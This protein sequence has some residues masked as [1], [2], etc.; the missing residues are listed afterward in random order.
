MAALTFARPPSSLC[1]LRLSAIGDVTHMLP[2]VATLQQ[3]WPETEI[4]WIIGRVEYQLVKSLPGIKF[5]IFDK[6][7]GIFEYMTLRRKLSG[8]RF[9]LLLMMQV[10]L[11]AN[12]ISLLIKSDM[13]IGYDRKRARD[14]HRLF[15]NQYIEGPDRVHVLDTFF[16]FL[17]KLGIRERRMNW[18]LK[19]D[20]SSRGFAQEIIGQQ[21]AVAI[22]PCSSARANNWRNWPEKNYSRVIDYLSTKGIRVIIT[23]GPAEEELLFA[24]RVI[25]NCDQKPVNLVGKTSLMQLLALLE[26]VRFLIAPDT[27]PA[28]MG[29]VAGIPVIGLYSS[30]NPLRTGPY[31]SQSILLNVY[32]DAL[33]KFN[34]KNLLQARWGERVRDPQVM[35]MITV[36]AVIDQIDQCLDI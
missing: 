20:E 10:A 4:T 35:S 21:P 25:E 11:R 6:R 9:D 8:Q 7:N 15:C 22:N 3:Q 32:P 34:G 19:A 24:E 27:G 1:I 28:H 18:L 31:N 14:F 2:I 23:G 5:I 29:T 17:E 30:S 36:Q 16:Q 13:A 33:Q 26:Q 12:L